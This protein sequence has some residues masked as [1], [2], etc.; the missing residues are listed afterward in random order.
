M[1][2]ITYD[3]KE[4]DANCIGCDVYDGRINMAHSII[5]EDEY[6]RIGQDTENPIRGFFVIGAVRHFR[7]FNEL[8]EEESRRLLPLMVETRRVM[9][10][11]LNIDKTTLIQEDGPDAMHFHPW[12]FPWYAWMDEIEG[13]E[14]GKIRDIMKYSREHMKTNDNLKE[15]NEAIV[16]ARKNFRVSFT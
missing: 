4:C 6:F 2:L 14:T 11:I 3:G 15:I 7:T 16:L 12:F 9:K 8:N 1:K 10:E 13:R 5:Y